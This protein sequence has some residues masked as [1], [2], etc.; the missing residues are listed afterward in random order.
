MSNLGQNKF[1]KSIDM[2]IIL[3]YITLV[4]IGWLNIYAAVFDESHASIF[5][6][7][8]NYGKQLLWIATALFIGLMVLH[9]R[10]H[11]TDVDC[12][13]VFWKICKWIEVLV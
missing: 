5:D 12:R 1:W 4:L 11:L 3:L 13:F 2:P 6:L 9:L 8:K 10:H 7:E